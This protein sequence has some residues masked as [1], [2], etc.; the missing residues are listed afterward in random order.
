MSN[1]DEVDILNDNIDIKIVLSSNL[2]YAAT[3]YTVSNINEL[4]ENTFPKYFVSADMVIVKDLSYSSIN[5]VIIDI[6]EKDLMHIC[7][8]MIGTISQI[9]SGASGFADIKNYGCPLKG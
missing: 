6:L 4:I 7:M 2:V 8:S 9:F 1:Y 5:K 3:L